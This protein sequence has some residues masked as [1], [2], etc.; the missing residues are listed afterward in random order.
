MENI[1]DE[2]VD[3]RS[4]FLV[5]HLSDDVV[6]REHPIVI[7][8]VRELPIFLVALNERIHVEVVPEGFEFRRALFVVGHPKEIV[9]SGREVNFTSPPAVAR[10]RFAHPTLDHLQFSTASADRDAPVFVGQTPNAG[11]TAVWRTAKRRIGN[12]KAQ[13]N[14]G[15]RDGSVRVFDRNNEMVFPFHIFRDIGLEKRPVNRPLFLINAVVRDASFHQ[16]E[17]IVYSHV[18]QRHDRIT[19]FVFLKH[20]NR[21]ADLFPIDELAINTTDRLFNVVNHRGTAQPRNTLEVFPEN[22]R[23]ALRHGNAVGGHNFRQESRQGNGSGNGW[24]A[25]FV[26][27]DRGKRQTRN[28][29][30]VRR[31]PGIHA[32]FFALGD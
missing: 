11:V 9:E 19:V 4:V 2:E 31:L 10:I 14:L 1:Q 17:R 22:N 18:A 8:G 6:N 29:N 13:G 30:G 28:V 21:N 3:P 27:T 23:T 32:R 7:V 16:K 15:F 12:R 25:H 5:T 24:P 20:G 26:T